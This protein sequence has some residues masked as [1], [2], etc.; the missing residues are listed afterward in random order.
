M[1]AHKVLCNF[2]PRCLSLYRVTCHS[3]GLVGCCCC[4]CC[5]L[6]HLGEHST[7]MASIFAANTRSGRESLGR[8]RSE[9]G[10]GQ[11]SGLQ[12]RLQRAS[13]KMPRAMVASS[14]AAMTTSFDHAFRPA[15]RMRAQV[16]A[17]VTPSCEVEVRMVPLFLSDRGH[18]V[19]E[20]HGSRPVLGDQ[21]PTNHCLVFGES[22]LWDGL[23]PVME[24]LCR[25]G[26]VLLR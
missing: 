11:S 3:V 16:D 24:R 5:S 13:A 2:L 21:R 20:A 8:K 10:L 12:G 23:E 9:T 6:S 7:S 14:A 17:D 26:R 18:L 4:C 25:A 15:D 19:E 22:P 1:C